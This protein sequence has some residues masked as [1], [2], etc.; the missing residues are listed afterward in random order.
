MRSHIRLLLAWRKLQFGCH[1]DQFRQGFSL[2]LPHYVAAVDFNS[3]FAGSELRSYLLIEHARDHQSHDLALAWG[4]Q[5]VALPQFGKLTLLLMYRP[6]PIQSL[7]NRIQQVL[8]P[9][10]LGQEFDRTR[11]HGLH[12][13]GNI[14][15]TSYEDNWY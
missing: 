1:S 6:G 4:Q 12:R 3:D 15:M 8:V 7:I 13:H 2:H 9:E 14:S 11:F 5:F 10:G